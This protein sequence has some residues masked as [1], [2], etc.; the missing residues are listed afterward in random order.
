MEPVPAATPDVTE[1]F[2]RRFRER[3]RG[4]GPVSFADFM[5]IALFDSEAGYYAARRERVGKGAGTDFYTASTF[6]G[7]F[8]PLV[9]AAAEK[10]LGG[11]G[12]AT[13]HTF[14][15]VG[16]EPGRALLDATA[17]AFA[18]SCVVRLGEIPAIPPAA[19]VFSNEL[20]D[21]Q[22]FHRLVWRGGAWRESGVALRGGRLAWEELPALSEEL[23]P[24]LSALPASSADGYT[25]DVPWRAVRRLERRAAP[26]WSGLFLA[27]DYGRAWRQISEDFPQGTGRGYAA[28]RQTGDLLEAP[29]AQDLTCHVCWDWLEAALRRAGFQTVQRDSQE[30]FFVKHATTA[31][32]AIVR[33]EPSPLSPARSQLKQLIHPSLMGHRFEALWAL[34]A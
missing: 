15:E 1:R 27:F 12:E 22:P 6:A 5:E 10:L 33:R 14:V 18:G 8:G 32:E 3:V 30:A 2:A 34:R 21:A 16:A 9:T 28:H 31:I 25:L 23:A 29:G 24:V 11:A 17:H 4:D 13:R 19:V 26:G 20:F 7:V